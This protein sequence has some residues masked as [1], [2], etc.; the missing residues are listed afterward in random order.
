MTPQ[1]N[2]KYIIKHQGPFDVIGDIH[3]C[4]N[5][6][7]TLLSKLDYTLD[8]DNDFLYA[9]PENRVLIF[10]GD[11]TDRGP[12]SPDVLKLVMKN[13]STGRAFCVNG[14][15]DDKL[16]RYLKGN[17]VIISHGLEDTVKQLALK[18]PSFLKEVST[19]LD[20]LQT[21]LIFDEGNLVV[22]HAAIKEKYIGQD[23]KEIRSFCLYGPT[24]GKLDKDGLPTRLPWVNSY[25]GKAL[26]AY[27]HET[28]K[29][30]II[31]NNSNRLIN[32][33]FF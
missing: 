13:V 22:T 7:T 24:T 33:I 8:R 1:I 10:V 4:F 2:E 11:L 31:E 12:N 16:R 14:N 15:H 17:S 6:L 21:H 3:G 20:S 28:I 5:E 18:S 9:H 25:T 27:G 30:S 32:P 26:I 19:F 23:S 29:E